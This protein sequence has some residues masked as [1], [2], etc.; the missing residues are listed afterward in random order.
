MKLAFLFRTAPHGN[1]ISREGLDALLAATAFCD[2]EEIGVFFI[3]DGVLNLLDGQN[4]ELL[5]QK[6]FIRTFKLLDLYDIEQRFVC[7][8][9]LDQYNL[10][11]EQLI[12]S[13]EKIDRT[14]LIN[15]LSQ[16]EKVFTF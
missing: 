1:A 8:D 6:D 14:S 9:S 13:A 5:L 2:E 10:N 4:P 16:A 3:D 12:I 7:T 11:T 15:K